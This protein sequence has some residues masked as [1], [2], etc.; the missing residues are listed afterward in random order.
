MSD[1]GTNATLTTMRRILLVTATAVLIAALSLTSAAPGSARPASG[2]MPAA[3]A[4]SLLYVKGGAIHLARADRSRDVVLKKGHWGW[5]SMDNHGVV[6]AQGPDGRT[7]PDG[8][9]GYSVFRMRQTG[10]VLGREATPV[11]FSTLNCP[12]YPANHVALSPDG[13]EL[14]YDYFDA[15]NGSLATWTP[16]TRFKPHTWTSYTAPRWLAGGSMVISHE[17]VTVTDTQAEIGIWRPGHSATGWS[18][19]IADTWATSYNA[20]VSRDGRKVA[21]IEDNAADYLDGAPRRVAM[22]FATAAGPGK[23][24]T[25]QCAI[26]LPTRLYRAWHGTAG[27]GMSFRADGGVL[28]WDAQNG[29][30]RA[31]TRSL[32]SCSA[33]SLQP[34]LWIRGAT[35]PY[36]SPASDQRA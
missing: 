34:R 1:G 6:A 33:A 2:R 21:L 27:V 17:G 26:S 32:R 18:T 9:A 10:R 31:T 11:D 19:S 24:L 35:D 23:P 13:T 30:W 12:Y 28:A 36:F 8:S 25:R 16:A 3:V 15:C 7:A 4:G 29:I 22:V 5:P 14:A 20:A